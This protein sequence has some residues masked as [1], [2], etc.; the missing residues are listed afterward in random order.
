MTCRALRW[1]VYEL[2]TSFYNTGNLP[3]AINS[4]HIVLIPKINCPITPRDFRPIS[5]CNVSYKIIAKSLANRI[6]NHLPQIIHPSQI[7]FVHGRHVASNIIIAQ[8]IVHSFNLRSWKQKAFLLKFDLAKAFDEWS[9]IVTTMRRQGF[10]N[11]FINLAYQ[12]ISTTN[13]AIIINGEQTEAFYPQRGIRQGCPL[14]PYLFVL[15]VNEL[16]INL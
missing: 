15:A 14:S 8:E 12:S 9:F 11:H 2:V 10:L 1:D 7:A 16:S 3:T 6:K 4:T 5:L 13:L